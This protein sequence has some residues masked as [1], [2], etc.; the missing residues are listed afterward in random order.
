MLELLDL[1]HDYLLFIQR[2]KKISNIDLTLYKEEQMKR[3]L[4]AFKTRKGFGTF[5][6]FYEHMLR[7]EALYNEF[8]D[9][10]TINVTEFF[11]NPSRWEV[12]EKK[13]IPKLASKSPKLKCWSAACSTGEE[14][15]SLAMLLA[16]VMDL[17][18]VQ[19]LATDINQKVIDQAKR[20]TYKESALKNLTPSQIGQFF[21]VTGNDYQ[22][23]AEIKKSVRFQKHNLLSD[24][25]EQG[26]DLIVCRNVLIYFTDEAKDR[27]FRKFS[28][29]LKTG[30]YLFVGGSE[31][32]F[33]PAQYGLAET[34][35]FFYKKM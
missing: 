3:R 17:K 11:R 13:I 28:R 19:I 35:T 12:L 18:D 16:S 31:Q 21:T 20:G 30:G 15:Y 33:Q 32:I 29:S 14:P 7:N 8:L 34:D 5:G 25:F 23:S 9:F 27:L 6:E 1:N 26:F 4:T 24:P 22:I 10:M 2:I